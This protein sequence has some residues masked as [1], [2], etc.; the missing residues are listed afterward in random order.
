MTSSSW[1]PSGACSSLENTSPAKPACM[2]P[3]VYHVPLRN[4]CF[5][6]DLADRADSTDNQLNIHSQ[7]ERS[8]SWGG[9]GPS[10]KEKRGKHGCLSSS[11]SWYTRSSE[12]HQ[13]V[14]ELMETVISHLIWMKF[15][16]GLL[17]CI[18]KKLF[19]CAGSGPQTEEQINR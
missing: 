15:V 1:K 5:T 13:A 4:V 8:S 10:G 9:Q 7:R 14:K 16:Y 19:L 11:C 12:I 17:A 18:D 3:P 6:S 2:R